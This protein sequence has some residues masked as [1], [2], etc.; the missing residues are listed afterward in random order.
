[1]KGTDTDPGEAAEQR[2]LPPSRG[3]T[4]LRMNLP[5]EGMKKKGNSPP[6]LSS[7]PFHPSVYSFSRSLPAPLAHQAGLTEGH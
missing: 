7:H 2:R 5:K 6:Y 4:A 3:P 1:M